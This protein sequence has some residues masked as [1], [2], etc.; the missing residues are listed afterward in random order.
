MIDDSVEVLNQRHQAKEYLQNV[1]LLRNYR[2]Q[3]SRN[4][5]KYLPGIQNAVMNNL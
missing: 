5:G 2:S 3:Q 4:N 1:Q